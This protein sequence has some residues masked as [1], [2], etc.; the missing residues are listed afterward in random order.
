MN[1]YQKAVVV[2]IRFAAFVALVYLFFN[3]TVGIFAGGL[4]GLISF[5]PII[6]IQG[7]GALVLYANA[8]FIAFVLTV[9][10]D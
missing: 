10:L 9:N 4:G 1:P 8:K 3:V 7:L 2:A 6:L 5:A